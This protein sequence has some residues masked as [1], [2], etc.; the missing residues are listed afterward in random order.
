MC[1]DLKVRVKFTCRNK[2]KRERKKK[3]HTMNRL[4]RQQ[5]FP[6]IKFNKND[7]YIRA[8]DLFSQ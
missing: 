8:A 2:R 1:L 7:F 6:L 3:K 4:F 5:L